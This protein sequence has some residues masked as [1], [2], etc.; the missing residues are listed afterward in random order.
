MTHASNIAVEA[1]LQQL[2][3]NQWCPIT[4]FSTKLKPAETRYSAFNRKLL[5][6]YLAIK[7]F[8][9]FVEG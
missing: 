4:F 6:I 1:V 9:H 3:D 8:Q 7:H 5:A 2:V